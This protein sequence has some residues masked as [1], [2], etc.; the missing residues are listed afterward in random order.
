MLVT[1]TMPSA[2]YADEAALSN[3]ATFKL[4]EIVVVAP[5]H[6]EVEIS[7]SALTSEAIYTFQRDSLDQAAQFIPSAISP[8]YYRTGH[9]VLTNLRVG[10]DLFENTTIGI[11]GRNLFYNNYMLADGYPEAGRTLFASFRVRY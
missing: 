7:G 2:A 10:Y 1:V 6:P 9:Y 4:G 5:R 11:G 3:D 8:L